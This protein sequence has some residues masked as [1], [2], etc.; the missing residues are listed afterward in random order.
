MYTVILN[1]DIEHVSVPG[2]ISK[3][4]GHADIPTCDYT[5]IPVGT[6]KGMRKIRGRGGGVMVVE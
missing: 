6:K 2:Q 4:P 1:H 3:G 5:N